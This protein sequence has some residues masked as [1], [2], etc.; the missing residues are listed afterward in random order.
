MVA[1]CGSWYNGPWKAKVLG[2]FK[3]RLQINRKILAWRTKMK[4]KKRLRKLGVVG[5]A[6]LMALLLALTFA[7]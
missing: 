3:L 2:H 1:G 4:T 7:L 5:T 6:V